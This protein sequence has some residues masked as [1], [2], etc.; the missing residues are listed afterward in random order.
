MGDLQTNPHLLVTA[1]VTTQMLQSLFIKQ[2]SRNREVQ[3][4]VET[5]AQLLLLHKRHL[6]QSNKSILS[7][8]VRIAEAEAV[9]PEPLK[10]IK[11]RRYS[12]IKWAVLSL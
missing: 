4:R 1:A 7:H 8:K 10:E 5:T 2:L 3:S 6:V 12:S 9:V 11:D